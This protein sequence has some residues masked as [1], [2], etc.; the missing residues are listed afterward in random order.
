MLRTTWNLVALALLA[1]ACR[2]PAD[3]GREPSRVELEG[4]HMGTRFRVVVVHEDPAQGLAAGRAALERVAELD[5]RL[6]DYRPESELSRLSR[7]SGGAPVPCSPD[8]W[9]VLALAAEVAERT[10]GAFDVTVGPAVRLWRRAGRRG[11]LP[12]EGELEEAR[13]RTGP[14][15]VDLDP[16]HRTARGLVPGMRLDLGGIAKGDALDQALEVLRSHGAAAGLVDGGGD[17]A[18]FGAPPGAPGWTIAVEGLGPG[19]CVELDEGALASSGDAYRAVEI[20]GERFSHL[21]DPRTGRALVGARAAGVLAR[22]A[23][24]ADALASALCV[25]GAEEGLLL[26]EAIPGVEGWIREQGIRGGEPCLSSGF[27]LRMTP[28]AATAAVP[29]SP[30]PSEP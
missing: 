17:V 12:E 4:H 8:L 25:L 13:R 29:R 20:G 21:V 3:G 10:G 15:L 26:L 1:G 7:A 9:R 28:E 19:A 11:E 14:D 24:L 18:V 30:Q 2:G 23:A 27:P 16:V 6:S 22:D 5:E